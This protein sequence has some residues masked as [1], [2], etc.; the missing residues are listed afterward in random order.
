LEQHIRFCTTSDGVRIAYA[1]TGQGPPLVRVLGW[2]THLEHEW[3]NPLFRGFIDGA[4]ASR[5]YVRYD[6]RGMGI[7]DRS[8]NDFSPEA[9][10][11][12]L[13]AVIDALGL[14]RFALQGLSQGGP[15]AI[16]YA[17]HHPERVTHL[18]LYG[19]FAKP[20]LAALDTDSTIG[21][22]QF[23]AMVTLIRHG[24]GKDVPA[25]RL[26]FTG[27]FMP[28]GDAEAIHQFNELGRVS[29]SGENA[30]ALFS[31]M[32]HIDVTD[33]LPQVK[34]PTLVVH[35]RGD[36]IIPFELGRK[37]A[38]GI[39]GARLLALE[40][41][42]H[43]IL[44]HEPAIDVMVEAIN[45][46]LAETREPEEETL[47]PAAAAFHA[48]A[49]GKTISHYKIIEQIGEGGMGVVYKAQDT[50]LNRSVALKFLPPEL[51]Q[52][53]G[54]KERFLREA[55]A[56]AALDH[57]NIC[58]TYEIDE[59]DGQTFIA[60][61]YIDGQDLSDKI[62]SGPLDAGEA[63]IIAIQAAEGLQD[64]HRRG[65][66][67]RDIKSANIMLSESGR[68]RVMD[69]GLAKLSG[70]TRLTKTATI[71]GTVNYMSPEQARGDAVDHRSDIW[72]L[73]VVLYEMLSGGMPP[74]DAE[75]DVASLHKIIYEEPEPLANHRKD[76]PPALLRILK[77]MM[78]KDPTDRYQDM[79][80]LIEDLRSSRSTPTSIP[81]AKSV[82]SIAV[83][84]FADM[85]AGKD[86]EYFCDGL[87][88]ELI[89]ALTQIKGMKV[90]ARTSAFSF[91]GQN[92]DI[93]DIG[94]KLGV[95]MVLEG[96]VRKA[97]NR[98]RI[99]AQLIDVAGG[100]HLW[101]EKYD[102]NLEDIFAIQDEISEAIFEKLRPKLLGEEEAKVAP[103]QTMDLEA[104]NLYLQGR[105]FWNKQ[106]GPAFEKAI[107][108]FEQA[109]RK[110]PNYAQAWAGIADCYNQLPFY[111]FSPPKEI[112]PK[113]QQATLK[114]LEID[115]LLAEGHSSL[116]SL[117]TNYERDWAGAEREF[118]RAI[119][120][121]PGYAYARFNYCW[122]LI[123]MNRCDEA[124]EQIEQALK[125]DPLSLVINR[126]FGVVCLYSG[127]LDKAIETARKTIEMN[128]EFPYVH[129]YLGLAYLYS[130][131][132][133]DAAREFE[134]ELQYMGG[135]DPMREGW[136]GVGYAAS[137][138]EQKAREILDRLLDKSNKGYVSP[139]LIG[140]IY[141]AM[142]DY[143]KGFEWLEKACD[144]MDP[145]LGFLKPDP[146]FDSIRSD[147]RFQALLKKIGLDE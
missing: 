40:G 71:M 54:A 55:H 123:F 24:W 90:I 101:S 50:K 7:S 51:M 1:I 44:P 96:S 98:L 77:K 131:R 49:I 35:R 94:R 12:D 57:P 91:K 36:A 78:H 122:H 15:T 110:D 112:Y 85:S 97:G 124:L 75:S 140:N 141:T 28:E 68:V 16:K 27:L 103:R 121:N 26:L 143:D 76:V 39:P 66:V 128:A 119:E 95:G 25:F 81:E 74:F 84:P 9:H 14:E 34:V 31:S 109:V 108:F 6:G 105:F 107:E 72:S 21:L 102:R 135:F 99:T 127:E 8:V 64:A 32:R 130:S 42:N 139:Y 46:F 116:G 22:E 129:F 80:T 48:Q 41:N 33:L 18:I 3:K 61:A 106:S 82:P 4:A 79:G 65:I 47:S 142:D 134:K 45:D 43:V 23:E 126:E 73:G 5:M 115:D 56:A 120:L 137:G 125:L 69:F 147:P 118:K 146:A 70:K 2:F 60:M 145:Y 83:L 17:I 63:V 20:R 92:I 138:N 67:H 62:E 104:Y 10:L 114:A 52:D 59:I 29:T 132:H 136:V 58:T 86:Q 111:S 19:S 113:A 87:A 89:N 13:E 37:L 30:A 93:R 11:L 117:K 133:E 38:T 88:E 53:V 144:E 100:H